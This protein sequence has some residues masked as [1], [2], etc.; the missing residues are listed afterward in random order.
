MPQKL[1]IG[2][3]LA[4]GLLLSNTDLTFQ[5]WNTGQSREWVIPLFWGLHII[6]STGWWWLFK[7][8]AILFLILH[9]FRI[10]AQGDK[11]PARKDK[12]SCIKNYWSILCW[13]TILK[14]ADDSIVGWSHEHPCN[15]KNLWFMHCFDLMP[16][17][18]FWIRES[19]KGSWKINRSLVVTSFYF[20]SET[21]TLLQDCN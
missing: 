9:S 2:T 14:A 6:V 4:D 13:S 7:Q 17:F 8:L 19:V 16:L 12:V 18:S 3:G 21:C 15:D 5:K 20:I 10:A 11:G 1:E